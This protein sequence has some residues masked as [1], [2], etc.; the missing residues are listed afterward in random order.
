MRPVHDTLRDTV[1]PRHPDH[2][3]RAKTA[4]PMSLVA[5]PRAFTL[6]E[7]LVVIGIIAVLISILLPTMGRAREQARRVNCLSNLRQIHLSIYE[8]AMAHKD[9]V[10]IGWRMVAA[11]PAKQFNSMF[12]SSTPSP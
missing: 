8:Y 1:M 2:P 10:P 6:V 12:F 11:K 7:L 9:V 4:N 3:A 5:G